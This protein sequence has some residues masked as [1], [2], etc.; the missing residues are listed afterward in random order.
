MVQDI[1]NKIPFQNFKSPTWL[2][3]QPI[4]SFLLSGSFSGEGKYFL[5]PKNVLFQLHLVTELNY[6]Q[7]GLGFFFVFSLSIIISKQSTK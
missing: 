4:D 1:R 3:F 6:L 5:S 2:P 7:F